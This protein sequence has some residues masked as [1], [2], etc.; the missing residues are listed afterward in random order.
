MPGVRAGAPYPPENR[1]GV[2]GERGLSGRLQ[3]CI[4]NNF[5]SFATLNAICRA[6]SLL[7]RL[8]PE[9]LLLPWR[10]NIRVLGWLRRER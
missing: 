5:G 3:S 4:R 10:K 9:V 8:V 6:S 1:K 7:R 2:G